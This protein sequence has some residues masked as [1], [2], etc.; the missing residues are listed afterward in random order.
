MSEQRQIKKGDIVMV[1]SGGPHMTVTNVGD[2]WGTPTAWC[3]WF[4][5]AKKHDDT[6]DVEALMIV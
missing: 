2:H 1:K 3:T 5:K 6:F 4:E